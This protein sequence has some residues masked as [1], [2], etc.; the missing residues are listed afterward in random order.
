M[1]QNDVEVAVH[2]MF[3]QLASW[4]SGSTHDSIIVPPNALSMSPIATTPSVDLVIQSVRA[5]P[6]YQQVLKTENSRKNVKSASYWPILS[7]NRRM[8]RPAHVY[9]HKTAAQND[10]NGGN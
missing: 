10:E 8:Q 3:E 7:A 6:K 4:T 2:V 9:P 5:S 1:V